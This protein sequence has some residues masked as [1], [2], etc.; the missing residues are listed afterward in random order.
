M[1]QITINGKTITGDFDTLMQW[2]EFAR[3]KG[4]KFSYVTIK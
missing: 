1:W 3:E 2:K 4:Y